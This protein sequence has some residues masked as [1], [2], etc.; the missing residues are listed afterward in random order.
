MR[1]I[2][3]IGSLTLF[4][5]L[6]AAGAAHA[7]TPAQVYMLTRAIKV[8]PGK[9]GEFQKFYAGTVRKYHQARKDAGVELGWMLTRLVLP[10]G[11]EAPHHYV[12][13]SYFSKFPQLD[14][15]PESRA[16]ML[17]KAGVT[18]E[19]FTAKINELTTLVSLTISL[20]I[21]SVGAIE[22]GDFVHVSYMKAAPGKT[23]QYIDLESR[24]YKPIQQKRIN[25]G[26]LSSWTFNRVLLPAGAEREFNF[27]TTNAVKKSEDL[28]NPLGAGYGAALF[29]KAHPNL[30]YTS[31]MNL[32]QELRTP[33]R[34]YIE[35][36]IDVLR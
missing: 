25:E 1:L 11:E 21:E 26:L 15:G 36:V 7:Q 19:Q 9:A 4:A 6:G 2:A 5:L 33:V 27:F 18:Q 13:T 23:A 22:P 28:G 29:S 17:Q 8:T 32:T 35:R 16:P 30:N 20:R 24:I 12:S 10:A 3:G 34:G 31:T 14:A